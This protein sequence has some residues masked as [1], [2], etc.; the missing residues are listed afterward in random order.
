MP[1]PE[2]VLLNMSDISVVPTNKTTVRLRL[3]CCSAVD[4]LRFVPFKR[5]GDQ[6]GLFCAHMTNQLTLF[7]FITKLIQLNNPS[8][9]ENQEVG[10][11]SGLLCD[12]CVQKWGKHLSSPFLIID[13][14]AMY[15]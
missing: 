3:K 4:S 15:L 11:Q 13:L 12:H 7:G 5:G 8:V 14:S 2:R 6:P 9:L 10:L 1:E